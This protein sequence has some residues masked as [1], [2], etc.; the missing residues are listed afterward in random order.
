MLDY[1]A[2]IV[3]CGVVDLSRDNVDLPPPKGV[4]DQKVQS[5]CKFIFL[6]LVYREG[7]ED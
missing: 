5:I 2:S 7:D 1:P 3:Q 4:M 6:F